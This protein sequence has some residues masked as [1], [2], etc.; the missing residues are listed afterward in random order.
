[1]SL[2]LATLKRSYLT[3]AASP[4]TVAADILSRIAAAG[5][6]A[7][8]ISRADDQ[9]L[10]DRAAALDALGPA[11]RAA[12]PLYGVPFAVKDNIDVAGMTTT[13][14]CPDFAYVAE[15]TA[16]AV[17]H[18]IAAG[19]MLVGKTNLDQ[20]ATG[21][22]GTRTP[23][24]VARNA[25]D[26]DYLPGGS[27]SGSAVAVSSG[28]V[29]FAFGTDTAGSGRVPAGFNN[30]VGLKPSRGLISCSGV[31]PA[32]RTLDCVSIFAL[33]AEDASR[34]LSVAAQYD[35]AD[36]YSRVRQDVGDLVWSGLQIGVPKPQDLFFDGDAETEA[37]FADAA[38]RARSLGATVTEIDFA[39]FAEVA[40]LLYQ[41]PWVAER[42]AAVEDFIAGHADSLWPVTRQIIGGAADI[43]AVHAFKSMYRL[44]DLRRVCA[45][46]WHDIDVMLVPT[47]PTIYTVAEEAAEPVLLNSRLGT[48]TN[49][50]NLLD[51]SAI[52]LPNGFLP[53]GLPAGVTFIAPAFHDAA[54]ARLGG[55]WQRA[56]G[57]PL[58]ATGQQ[59][60]SPSQTAST[61]GVL[62]AVVGAH[63][64]GEPLAGELAALGATLQASTTTADAY[65]LFA[66]NGTTPPKP[67]LMRVGPGQ[68]RA[69]DVEVYALSSEAF[70]RFAAAVPAPLG[71]GSVE[72][73]DGRAVKGFICEPLALDGARDITAFGGWRAYQASLATTR[74]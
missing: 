19:A 24:G 41:G 28:L 47:S 16:P 3:G 68:G 56:T 38:A 14:A 29:S 39:P 32:C 49:F 62:L 33:T 51:L 43:S 67:G 36:A 34:V 10:M 21:L 53:N 42:L 46:V 65:R 23:Y 57:L 71:I 12:L 70:G 17:A 8:W 69:I 9:A 55:G 1:M 61:D 50:V 27:S 2:D 26:A 35:A 64:S 74:S 20:F 13:A 54:L 7:V 15:A 37:L 58:G 5:D 48:Y 6:D 45:N 11:E 18:L 40:A 25:F 60:P 44:E 52:A 30:I 22:V 59:L 73:A 72:L 4:G 63:L 31:V 66:L